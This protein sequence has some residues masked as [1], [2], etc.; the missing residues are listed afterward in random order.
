MNFEFAPEFTKDTKRLA[1]K[2]SS[3]TKDVEAAKRYILPLYTELSDD[4][5]VELYRRD[6]LQESARLSYKTATDLKWLRCA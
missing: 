5:S 2:W 4:V 6:F 3:I 1:K